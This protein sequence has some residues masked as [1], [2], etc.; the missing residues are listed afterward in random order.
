VDAVTFSW[1][2][3]VAWTGQY[4]RMPPVKT[5]EQAGAFS[6]SFSWWGS[7]LLYGLPALIIFLTNKPGTS[8]SNRFARF[9]AGEALNVYLTWLCVMVPVYILYLV[10]FFG[11]FFTSTSTHSNG[12]A[13]APAFLGGSFMLVWGVMMVSGLS[14]YAVF[15]L[16]AVRSYRGVWWKARYAIPFLRAH[17]TLA[18][19]A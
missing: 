3:G 15:I 13:T 16:A 1:W 12:T 2:N 5:E 18:P 14:M 8:G 4:Y 19:D 7:L 11:V 10:T 6:A 17:R 9:S